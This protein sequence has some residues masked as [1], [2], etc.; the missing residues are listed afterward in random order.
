MDIV[1]IVLI[2]AAAIFAVGAWL[3]KSLTDLGLAVL[4]LAFILERLG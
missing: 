1:L 4:T 2:L 3:S